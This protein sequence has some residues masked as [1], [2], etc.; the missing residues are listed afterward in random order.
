MGKRIIARRR[1]SGSAV[2]R[3]PSHKHSAPARL[4]DITDGTGVVE[5]ISHA[6]GRSTPLA[7]VRLPDGEVAAQ[8]AHEGIAV[9]DNMVYT[10]AKLEKV[11]AGTTAFVGNIPEGTPVFNLE[12]T[13]GDGGK[14]CRAGGNAAYVVSHN[15]NSTVVLLPSG[16]TRSFHPK[17]RATI[18]LAAGGGAGDKP[19]LKAGKRYHKV[20]TRASNWPKVRGVA[21]NPVDHPHGGGSHNFVGGNT[22]HARGTPPGQLVGKVAP[23]RT[24][25]R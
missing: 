2:Y 3:S 17:S 21:M 19:Y 11:E 7:F 4:P 6:P 9:G 23:K 1:G 12:G 14:F 18:G 25:K 15:P 5:S 22:S 16:K 24:G 8:I 20:K 10:E 13:P